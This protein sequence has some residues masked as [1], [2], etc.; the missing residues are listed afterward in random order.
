MDIGREL[1]A[2]MRM[3]TR[4]GICCG[5][6]ADRGPGENRRGGEGRNDE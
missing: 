5:R 6:Q 2:M 1:R 3:M 4:R